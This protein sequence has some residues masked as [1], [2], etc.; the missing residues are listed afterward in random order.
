MSW[1]LINPEQ[2]NIFD[3]FEVKRC[4]RSD[5]YKLNEF[6]YIETKLPMS[7]EEFF[8]LYNKKSGI[9][10]GINVY[11]TPLISLKARDRTV[12][13]KMVF[14]QGR[15]KSER[16]KILNKYV[17]NSQRLI[18]H[19]SIRGIGFAKFLVAEAH[20][21]IRKPFIEHVSIMSYENFFLPKDYTYYIRVSHLHDLRYLYIKL[22]KF[23][24]R[25]KGIRKRVMT[26][27]QTYGYTL[28][29][30]KDLL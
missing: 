26:P 6:H 10:Y 19:P 3:E 8:G 28:Y 22:D 4:L 27:L 14:N 7:A 2:K 25:G 17:A 20:K 1:Q 5:Y 18:I 15:N 23:N 16:L 30:K 13:G 29:I 21:L 24:A 11:G 12:L 9:L